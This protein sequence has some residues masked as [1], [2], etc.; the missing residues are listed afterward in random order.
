MRRLIIASAALAV[1]AAA[2][3]SFAA[4]PQV[5]PTPLDR[6]LKPEEK[7]KEKEK[8][9]VSNVFRDM[10]V[11]QRRAMI[12]GGRFLFSTFGTFDFSDGPYTNYSI[13][14]NPGYAIS[15]FLEIYANI[16]PAY[17]VSARSIV[18]TV[19]QLQ[20]TGGHQ[21]EI[22]AARPRTQLGLDVIWAPAY[23]KDS[24]GFS[25]V[26]RSDTFLK[27]G[28]SQITYDSGNGLK[29]SVGV[30]KT[31]FLGRNMGFR[32][33]ADLGYLQN[34]INGVKAFRSMALL[35]TGIVFYL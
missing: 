7:D 34:I 26:I 33:C 21:A 12:K 5:P 17:I 2:E 27:F 4:E 1:L 30:G 24:F 14:F 22:V 15:D 13:H 19:A 31:Y 29:F 3:A 6:T 23:G 9:E 11:V 28:A 32:F 18:D 10:G 16:A 20:L 35:E 25:S 8:E